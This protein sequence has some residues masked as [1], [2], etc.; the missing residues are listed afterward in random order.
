MENILSKNQPELVHLPAYSFETKKWA[1]NQLLC[2]IDEV[3]RGC[4]AGPVVAC[5]LVLKPFSAHPLLVDSKI[6]TEKQRETAANWIQHN[7]WYAFGT[8]S[9][10]LIDSHNIYAATQMAMKKA[11]YGLLSLPALMQKPDLILIDAMPLYLGAIEVLSFTKGESKSVS[12]AAASIMA[13]V[14][15]DR[16]MKRLDKVFPGYSFANN[17]GYGAQVHTS[18]LQNEGTCLIHRKS[19]LG[20]FKK[21]PDNEERHKQKTLFC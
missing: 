9:H 19:F 5:C 14:M 6:L 4:L 20:S 11:F 8:I 17:K 1:Q 10:S 16:L 12:I 3:G 2:G 15:R 13:K 18:S 7:A 21:G